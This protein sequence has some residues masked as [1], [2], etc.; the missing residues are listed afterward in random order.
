METGVHV[1][2]FN[3]NAHE[4]FFYLMYTKIPN[5]STLTAARPMQNCSSSLTISSLT[6]L[7]D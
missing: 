5:I 1:V 4:P 7:R 3:Q 2:I 6:F